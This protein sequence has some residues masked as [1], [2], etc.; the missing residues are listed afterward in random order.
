MARAPL[1]ADATR[2]AHFKRMVGSGT[3]VLPVVALGIAAFIWGAAKSNTA[4]MAGGPPGILVAALVIAFI[5]ADRRAET[6]FF[7][8]F[9]KQRGLLYYDR[10]AILELTPLLGAGDRRHCEHM[11]EGEFR[12]VH[13]RLAHFIYEIRH[14][15]SGSGPQHKDRWEKRH[16]TVCVVDMEDALMLFKG[17]FLR[18]RRGMFDKLEN[19][20]WLSR[21]G[22][23]RVEL[24]S[25]AFNER[26]ELFRDRA[27]DENLLRQL[28][29]PSLVEWLAHHPLAPGVEFKAGT[30]VVFLE[31]CIEEAGKLDWLLEAAVELSARVSREASEA[32][33]E[34][35]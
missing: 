15:S 14:E 4:V 25:I 22:L 1:D 13:M 16:F 20:E 34:T 23:P 35:R 11:M 10:G 33:P 5:L 3:F 7:S 2:G 9:A 21:R 12:G 29:S 31:E 17:F 30:L 27:M 19:D 8:G 28:F 6:D 24:E 32:I 18:T 26:Y